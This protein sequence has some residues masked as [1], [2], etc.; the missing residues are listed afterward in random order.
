[1]LSSVPR[2]FRA[3][4]TWKWQTSHAEYSEADGWVLTTSFRGP[5]SLDVE[6]V[7]ADGVWTTTAAA[8]DTTEL[9]AG[10]YLWQSRVA[11]DD[12]VFTIASGTVEVLA[13]LAELAADA[14]VRTSAERQL[15]LCEVAIESLITKT[16]SSAS[17]GDQSYTLVDIDKLYRIRAQL[18]N[19]VAA[20]RGNAN[21]G[22]G[23]RIL[24]KFSRL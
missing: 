11:L 6:A 10:N 12:E 19:E 9:A 17:F 2:S 5:S 16:N 3:G 14:D 13:G 15:A 24:V 23:R 4:D 7:G 22:A 1:M 8:T 20:Q 18:R 21:G